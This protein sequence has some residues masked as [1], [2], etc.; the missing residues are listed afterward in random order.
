MAIMAILAMASNKGKMAMDKKTVHL[1]SK[2]I[3]GLQSAFQESIYLH[4]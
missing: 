4:L 2:T 1:K 3:F